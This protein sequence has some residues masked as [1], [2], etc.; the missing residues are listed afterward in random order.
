MW[1]IGVG[2]H[3]FVDDQF[4]QSSKTRPTN[5]CDFGLGGH[6]GLNEG[7]D[8]LD[9]FVS[10]E[11]IARG[12]TKRISVTLRSGTYRLV[13]AL[14]CSPTVASLLGAV[15]SDDF[16]LVDM[17][18]SAVKKHKANWVKSDDIARRDVMLAI[19]RGIRP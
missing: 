6:L 8:F 1:N 17:M 15:S 3:S 19:E 16:V 9:A 5:D 11:T 7:H 4:S 10:V 14:G 12:N 2:N 13:T 18:I